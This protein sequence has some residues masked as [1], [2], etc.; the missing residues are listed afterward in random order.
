MAE[1]FTLHP[2]PDLATASARLAELVAARL[3]IVLARQDRATLALPGGTT[4]L[5]FL[6]ALG[7]HDLPW[8]RIV[9]LPGDERFVP[10]DDLQSNERQIRTHFA[11]VGDHRCT[12]VSLRGRAETPEAAAAQACADPAL[13]RPVDLVICGMGS[14]GHIASL[15]PGMPALEGVVGTHPAV[16]ATHPSGLAPRLTLSPTALL[17][18]GWR[19]LLFA[20]PAK[21]AVFSRAC[22]D[23][24][25][26]ELPVRLLLAGPCEICFG[27]RDTMA[28]TS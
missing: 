18:A 25:V 28:V 4:P 2:C 14:D 7:R 22:R 3:S 27:L 5:L 13:A 1:R 8:N 21:Q 17:G 12:F 20:G 15:F 23:G 9:A 11:P 19:A 6:D 24:P 10:P 16:I 26:S